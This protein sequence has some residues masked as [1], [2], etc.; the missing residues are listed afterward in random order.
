MT[1]T[2]EKAPREW[3]LRFDDVRE[4]GWIMSAGQYDKS[5]SQ[6]EDVPVIEK[7]A[8]DAVAAELA[9]VREENE[10]LM[11]TDYWPER[12]K[13]AEAELTACQKSMNAHDKS[14]AKVILDRDAWRELCVRLVEALRGCNA[15]D[16]K[17]ELAEYEKL[18][19]GSK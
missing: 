19:G 8:Y 17:S 16:F 18:C 5:H 14:R 2:K 15:C 3:T 12:R 4:D 11:S 6:Q 13:A 1:D 9:K 10:R 7:S